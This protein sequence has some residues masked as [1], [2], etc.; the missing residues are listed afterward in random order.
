MTVYK[1]Q[2]GPYAFIYS[3]TFATTRH[4]NLELNKIILLTGERVN[5]VALGDC[6]CDKGLYK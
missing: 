6:N 4:G 2:K 3:P 5:Y 1:C